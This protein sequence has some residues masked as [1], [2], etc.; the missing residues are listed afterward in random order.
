MKRISVLLVFFLALLVAGCGSDADRGKNKDKDLPRL[1]EPEKPAEK[2]K[3]IVQEKD[4]V[5]E[6][7]VKA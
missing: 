4:K 3:D 6:K 2:D 7:K 5:K 1:G